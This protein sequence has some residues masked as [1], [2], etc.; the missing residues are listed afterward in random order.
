M[1]I[2]VLESH[3]REPSSFVE[4]AGPGSV[5]NIYREFE[6]INTLKSA[7]R[8]R[9]WAFVEGGGAGKINLSIWL[10]W[11]KIWSQDCFNGSRSRWKKGPN[12]Q[13]WF[14]YFASTIKLSLDFFLPHKVEASDCSLLQWYHQKQQSSTYGPLYGT[15]G[16]LQNLISSYHLL[17]C[18]FFG[19][20]N[21]FQIQT[22]S[23]N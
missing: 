13:H 17:F 6:P 12:I 23:R 19:R 3:S 5:K 4:E 18:V 9:T 10:L 1:F 2:L 16:N 8:S 15:I 22:K 21:C 20:I 11:V 7:L 14:V